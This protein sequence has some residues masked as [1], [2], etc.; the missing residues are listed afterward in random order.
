[1]KYNNPPS[2]DK[3]DP[4]YQSFKNHRW[5]KYFENGINWSSQSAALRLEFGRWICREHSSVHRGKKRLWKF[6]INLITENFAN[7]G[8]RRRGPSQSLWSHVCYD[9][10][11]LPERNEQ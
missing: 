8:T 2:T 1:M 9:K 7:D 5:F 6:D 3:P 4:F 11:P 10:V